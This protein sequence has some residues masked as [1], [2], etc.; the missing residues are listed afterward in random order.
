MDQP[1]GSIVTLQPA[2]FYKTTY[3]N[4]P[5]TGKNLSESVLAKGLG[6]PEPV[7][8]RWKET[9]TAVFAEF[10]IGA[11]VMFKDPRM[12]AILNQ[13]ATALRG[14]FPQHEPAWKYVDSIHS[15]WV[16]TA[17]KRVLLRHHSNLRR[18]KAKPSILS[19][20]PTRVYRTDEAKSREP[21]SWG[22]SDFCLDSL[23]GA[24]SDPILSPFEFDAAKSRL[25]GTEISGAISRAL[26]R[27]Q[28]AGHTNVTIV[29]EH[30]AL[31]DP[32]D[33]RR[34][35]AIQRVENSAGNPRLARKRQRLDEY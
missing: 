6:I 24:L 2:E 25:S 35:A 29:I 31:R 21:N 14:R 34:P 33:A 28:E 27:M 23:I 5:L 11:H 13:M 16:A 4:G 20:P 18:M 1:P 8:S 12:I 26:K 9:C 10:D 19:A 32:S 3:P 17:L 22:S 30:H 15:S 7:I